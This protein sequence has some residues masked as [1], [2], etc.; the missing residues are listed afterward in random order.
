VLGNTAQIPSSFGTQIG[1]LEVVD[2]GGAEI[3]PV[4]DGAGSN[5]FEPVQ[6]LVTH[7]HREVGRHD[8]AVAVDSSYRDGVGVDPSCGVGV[9]VEL[10]DVDGLERG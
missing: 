1:C 8:V 2:K 4:V 10:I 7:H 3:L 6:H 9:A 5:S